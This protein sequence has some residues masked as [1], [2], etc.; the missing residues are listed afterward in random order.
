MRASQ[1]RKERGSG[2]R[3]PVEKQS[4]DYKKPFAHEDFGGPETLTE[5]VSARAGYER[6][7]RMK[8]MLAEFERK[9]RTR[10][11]KRRIGAV[12]LGLFGVAVTVP[13]CILSAFATAGWWL[14]ALGVLMILAA[15][16]LLYM[17]PRGNDANHAIMCGLRH[18][19]SL[20]VLS[21]ALDMDIS[22]EKAE[23]I[24]NELVRK[25]IAEID[26]GASGSDGAIVYRITGL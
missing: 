15:G 19:G 20:T 17:D 3:T 13:S 7:A 22:T 16:L 25:G 9:L 18:G 26:L 10:R 6:S 8:S 24:I 23:K 12:V 1:A 21:L 11:W 14:T 5:G 2:G 4:L